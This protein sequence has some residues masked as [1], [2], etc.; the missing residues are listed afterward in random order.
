MCA[1]W[2]CAIYINLLDFTF[3]GVTWIVEGISD[4]LF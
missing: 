4:A 3:T 2:G 1:Q